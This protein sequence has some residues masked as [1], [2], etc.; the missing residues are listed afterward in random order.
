MPLSG[1]SKPKPDE[2]KSKES[3]VPTRNN[4]TEMHKKRNSLPQMILN[5]AASDVSLSHI[6][7]THSENVKI[8]DIKF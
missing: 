8:K 5:A 6:S 7:L 4:G 3:L 2:E 1:V